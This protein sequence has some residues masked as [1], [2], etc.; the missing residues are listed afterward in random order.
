VSSLENFWCGSKECRKG[1]DGIATGRLWTSVREAAAGGRWG[2]RRK[3]Q[4]AER[5]QGNREDEDV[6]FA[7]LPQIPMPLSAATHVTFLLDCVL[8]FPALPAPAGT[9][10]VADK[11]LARTDPM[12]LGTGGWGG[13]TAEQHPLSGS[14]SGGGWGQVGGGRISNPEQERQELF[15]NIRSWNLQENRTAGGG[16]PLAIG[17]AFPP[18]GDLF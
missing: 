12:G 17:G 7:L 5:K 15:S 16:Y 3:G 10:P 2:E 6:K 13:F 1:G 18:G 14:S 4:R 8:G 9:S 11:R